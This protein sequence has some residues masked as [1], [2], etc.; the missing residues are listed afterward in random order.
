MV[1]YILLNEGFWYGISDIEGKIKQIMTLSLLSYI[2]LKVQHFF[3]QFL[4]SFTYLLKKSYF[5]AYSKI[6]KFHIMLKTLPSPKIMLCLPKGKVEWIVSNTKHYFKIF[7]FSPLLYG[8]SLT[9]IRCSFSPLRLQFRTRVLLTP[10][11]LWKGLLLQKYSLHFMCSLRLSGFFT[12]L[13][14][15]NNS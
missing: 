15:G 12:S 4:L 1:N 10:I 9:V 6:G 5:G 8:I 14:G 13:G 2:S 11:C 3:Y 7:F